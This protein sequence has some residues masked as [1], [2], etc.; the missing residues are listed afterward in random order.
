M[1]KGKA[2]VVVPCVGLGPH[3]RDGGATCGYLQNRISCDIRKIVWHLGEPVGYEQILIADELSR[4]VQRASGVPPRRHETL[5]ELVRTVAAQRGVCGPEDLISEGPTRHEVR[6]DGRVL[7]T[8]CFVDALMLPF[9]FRGQ[10][11]EVRS[12]SPTGGEV[13]ALVTEGGVEGS[14]S[15]AVVSFG[16]ARS[17][18]GPTHATLCPY[19]NAFPS[20]DDYERWAEQT[21]QAETVALS[22]E[23]AFGLAR[24]WISGS[25]RGLEGEN[26]C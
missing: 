3:H 19:L 10:Q 11:V 12:D 15:E 9:L 23:E 26:C 25:I 17:G 8:F 2:P 6:V 21:P 5:G 14:P 7:Y 16:A 1:L 24:D 20:R 4:S 13:T 18:D 22:M